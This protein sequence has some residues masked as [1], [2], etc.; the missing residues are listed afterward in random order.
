MQSKRLKKGSTDL[1][2]MNEETDSQYQSL[3]ADELLTLLNEQTEALQNLI[4]RI[5]AQE[6][7][8]EDVTKNRAGKKKKYN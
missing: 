8:Q 5:G 6:K 1:E 3:N 2:S 4:S 7:S